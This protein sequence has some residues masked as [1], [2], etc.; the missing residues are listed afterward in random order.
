MGI[1]RTTWLLA[2]LACL[3]LA[4]IV[5]FMTYQVE[6]DWQFILQFRGKR[7]L[8]L[9]VAALALGVGTLIF[10]T[11]T[12]SKILTPSLLGLDML[13][14]LVHSLGL[15]VWAKLNIN[16]AVGW[17]FIIN[18]SLM[19]LLVWLAFRY[20]FNA[21]LKG[22]HLLILIGL[23][24]SLFFKELADFLLRVV[25]PTE[26]SLGS[27]SGQVNI[28]K[29]NT[30]LLTLGLVIC[31]AVV[32]VVFNLRRQLDVLNLGKDVAVSLGVNYQR[33]TNLLLLMSALLVGVS[34]ALIGPL[35]FFGLLVANLTYWLLAS[36]L[37][38]HTLGGVIFLAIILL[39]GGS[40]LFNQVFNF[41]LAYF[42]ILEF[43][44]GV[45]FVL[46]LLKGIKK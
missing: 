45:L 6:S 32:L 28:N 11:L 26:F 39:V 24:A 30:G 21:S 20:V 25:N 42:L 17:V 7:L 27:F 23:V 12:H 16:L 15:L 4:T 3:A 46:L 43:I 31:L 41:G 5:A 9:L 19:L 2:G 14:F 8:A 34:T 33:L 18:L 13:Y 35:V 37:H 40:V 44:G 36:H 29:P 1:A 10:Q 22:I 38:S